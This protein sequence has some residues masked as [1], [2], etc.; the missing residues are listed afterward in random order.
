MI[1]GLTAIR[2]KFD[3]LVRVPK[4]IKKAFKEGR[5]VEPSVN[6][7][8]LRVQLSVADGKI[9]RHEVERAADAFKKVLLEGYDV[10]EVMLLLVKRMWKT[11][12]FARRWLPF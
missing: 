5:D 6:E 4:A 10:V 9:S 3:A 2:N 1:P 11:M 7:L 12:R 8:I